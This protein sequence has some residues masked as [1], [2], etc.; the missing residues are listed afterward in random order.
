V[1]NTSKTSIA[2]QAIKGF[3]VMFTLFSELKKLLKSTDR[4]FIVLRIL[5][6][7]F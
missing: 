3:F 5:I 6:H 2:R 4:L 7:I 1:A